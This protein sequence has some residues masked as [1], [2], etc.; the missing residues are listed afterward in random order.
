MSKNTVFDACCVS[1]MGI[2]MSVASS[3]EG[4]TK[5]DMPRQPP[6]KQQKLDTPAAAAGPPVNKDEE[7]PTGSPARYNG[8][9]S[10]QA[11][12]ASHVNERSEEWSS[13][14]DE[15]ISTINSEVE[16]LKLDV[17]QDGHVIPGSV[18]SQRTCVLPIVCVAGDGPGLANITSQITSVACQR[19]VW[20]IRQPTLGVEI[21]DSGCHARIFVAWVQEEEMA[22]V[23]SPSMATRQSQIPSSVGLTGPGVAGP[24][25]NMK[26]VVTSSLR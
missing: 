6:L 7:S 4:S 5:T 18:D 24:P 16:I 26:R 15:I 21:A 22:V 20:G 10:A 12:G 13:E 19:Y 8:N 3:N 25:P 11:D 14:S 23:R 1:N 2:F 17:S 9:K